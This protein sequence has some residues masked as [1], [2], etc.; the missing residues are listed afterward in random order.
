[1][2]DQYL[3]LPLKEHCFKVISCTFF[4]IDNVT[5]L[6]QEIPTVNAPLLTKKLTEFIAQNAKVILSS[7]ECSEEFIVRNPGLVLALLKKQ[8]GMTK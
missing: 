2:A 3:I 6:A 7:K 8:A 4:T 1:M 5:K